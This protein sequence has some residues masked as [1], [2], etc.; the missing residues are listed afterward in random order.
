[1]NISNPINNAE[2]EK[3]QKSLENFLNRLSQYC[4]DNNLSP[5]LTTLKELI[6][7]LKNQQESIKEQ[8]NRHK[9]DLNKRQVN[10]EL[11]QQIYKYMIEQLKSVPEFNG[12]SIEILTNSLNQILEKITLQEFI[13]ILKNWKRNNQ[14][15]PQN[16]TIIQEHEKTGK[17]IQAFV[18]KNYLEDWIK[19]KKIQEQNTIEDV[20]IICKVEELHL[21]QEEKNIDILK[22]YI[23]KLIQK[24]K[25]NTIE[26]TINDLLLICDIDDSPYIRDEK[27]IRK[28]QNIKSYIKKLIKDRKITYK[29][30]IQ[31]LLDLCTEEKK[32]IKKI[33][34]EIKIVQNQI[35]WFQIN[36][37][38]LF[39]FGNLSIKDFLDKLKPI[40]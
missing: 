28:I 27:V 31:N 26:N 39:M 14:K 32:R 25:I 40:V 9:K 11:I 38:D 5:S 6:I 8:T 21:E 4:Q 7:F 19:R 37:L 12:V 3:K 35:K 20:L 33:K 13:L 10:I 23:Q 2:Q 16:N 22:S 17:C 18:L 24:K 1:M 36:K 15:N 30:T 34:T 29:T